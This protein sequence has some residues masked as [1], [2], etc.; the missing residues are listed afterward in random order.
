MLLNITSEHPKI[1][2]CH[3]FDSGDS[4]AYINELNADDDDCSDADVAEND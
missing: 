4:I 2:Q 1:E 3:F